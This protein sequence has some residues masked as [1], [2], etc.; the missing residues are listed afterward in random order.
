M[1]ALINAALESR[2]NSVQAGQTFRTPDDSVGVPYS[3]ASH[4]ATS[5]T[6]RTDGGTD[7][8][9]SREAFAEALGYLIRE[10][11]TS[12]RRKCEVGSTYGNP[13]PLSQAV[14]Q[15]N[16][17]EVVVVAY[18]LPIQKE[19]GLVALNGTRPNSTWLA[20]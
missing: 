11:H 5:M 18:V 14:S 13:G 17:G 8:R 4:G 9:I 2:W 7:I 15:A 1:R 10:G 12:E 3:I 6:I 19:M 20:P 16:C